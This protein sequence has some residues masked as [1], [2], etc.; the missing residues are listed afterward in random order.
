MTDYYADRWRLPIWAH[1][2]T[3]PTSAPSA[4]THDEVA[5]RAPRAA[6]FLAIGNIAGGVFA[7]LWLVIASHELDLS[8]FGRLTLLISLGSLVSL[9]TDLGV[10][11]ALTAVAR[12][13]GT[14]D[15]RAFYGAVGRRLVAA[16]VAV[17]LLLVAWTS[18]QGGARWS[19]GALYG[20]SI[21]AGCVTGSWLAA[22]R[23]RAAP[24][25]EAAWQA[26]SKLVLI[27]AGALAATHGAGLGV[28]VGCYVAIDVVGAL[29]VARLGERR[30]P[31]EANADVTQRERLAFR[32]ALPLA[33]APIVGV[34]YER[35]DTWLVGAV[36][37]A[38]TVAIYA[39]AY[40]VF[41]IA[42]LPARSVAA[43][44]IAA[45]GT[46]PDRA[47]L[48]GLVRRSL[49]IATPLAAV[50]A[51]VGPTVLRHGFGHAFTGGRG[52]VLLLASAAIPGAILASLTPIALLAYRKA[53]VLIATAGLAINV[54]LNVAM[55]TAF[56]A[57]GAAATFAITE[58]VMAA[59]IW[60]VLTRKLEATVAV[61]P[62]PTVST[63]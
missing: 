34:A 28:I 30:L 11:L 37:G 12:D 41:D 63:A 3:R 22:L 18:S 42:M 10:P 38:T 25:I 31:F 33:A 57:T 21:A 50:T 55:I 6:V 46:A 5:R 32:A 29:V 44:S 59:S 24:A 20:G 52:S 39:A 51:L 58:T 13:S 61:A 60:I 8:T 43:T 27:G 4:A 49:L 16:S 54:G 9:V 48:L 1:R 2:S 35:V 40:K 36:R 14:L 7:A 53:V 45:L 19:T 62:P 23:G 15:R 47:R 26:L 56:G 17:A